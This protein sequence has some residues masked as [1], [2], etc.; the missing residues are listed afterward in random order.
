M[1]KPG[2]FLTVITEVDFSQR[3]FLSPMNVDP[4]M[5]KKN[6]MQQ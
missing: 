4:R 2:P 1:S 6:E 3:S 5:V